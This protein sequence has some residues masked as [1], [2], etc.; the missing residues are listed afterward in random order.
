MA[1]G[2][3]N[4]PKSTGLDNEYTVDYKK[5]LERI[6]VLETTNH[7]MWLMLKS[8]GFTDEEFDVAMC[9][10]VDARRQNVP[11]TGL[12]CP[13]CGKSAQLSSQYKIKCIY[14]GSEAII[15]PYEVYEIIKA[16][17]EAEAQ[18]ALEAAALANQPYD[19]TKDLRFDEFN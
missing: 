12:R 3:F 16:Q 17:A 8:K 1:F 7:A 14:C 2:S 13:N 19:V 6:D 11:V 4:E 18:A 5:L 15:H 10:A 9:N